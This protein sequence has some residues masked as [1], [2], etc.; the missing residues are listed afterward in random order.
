MESD[1]RRISSI[2]RVDF[3]R[4]GREI[5]ISPKAQIHVLGPGYKTEYFIESIECSI[6]IGK[7]HT[8][9]LIMSLEAWE[10]LKAGAEVHVTTTEEYKRKYEYKIRR[11]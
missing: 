2:P 6:G 1:V 4:L 9:S 8:A 5:R 3:A 11:K 10:A 7:D